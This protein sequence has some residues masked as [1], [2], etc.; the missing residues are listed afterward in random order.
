MKELQIGD[1]LINRCEHDHC[2]G[3]IATVQVTASNLDW[4]Q[5]AHDDAQAY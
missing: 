2:G 1:Y 3:V 4:A 5:R